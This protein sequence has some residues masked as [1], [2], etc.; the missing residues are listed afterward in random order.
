M[1]EY[2]GEYLVIKTKYSHVKQLTHWNPA[3]YTT[4]PRRHLWFLYCIISHADHR[5]SILLFHLRVPFPQQVSIVSALPTPDFVDLKSNAC[6]CFNVSPHPAG[7][8]PLKVSFFDCREQGCS[9]ICICI[10]FHKSLSSNVSTVKNKCRKL[11]RQSSKLLSGII[12]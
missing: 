1:T 8:W 5:K 10:C 7:Y 9:C 12:S 6:I 4:L 11:S 2:P 3:F